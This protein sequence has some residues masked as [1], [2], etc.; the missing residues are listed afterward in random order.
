MNNSHLVHVRDVVTTWFDLVCI[1][2]VYDVYIVTN[3][4][5]EIKAKSPPLI[6]RFMFR[7]LKSMPMV[8]C[9]SQA[10]YNLDNM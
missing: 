1:K 6:Y 2:N 4:G 9:A 3:H 5:E 7:Q 8:F 10:Q